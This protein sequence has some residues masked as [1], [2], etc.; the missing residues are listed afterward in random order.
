MQ[1]PVNGLTEIDLKR[2][3]VPTLEIDV[4]LLGRQEIRLRL[5]GSGDWF[6]GPEGVELELVHWNWLMRPGSGD[7]LNG[8]NVLL[9]EVISHNRTRFSLPEELL[10]PGKGITAKL[11]SRSCPFLL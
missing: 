11:F 8:E 2:L 6:L 5:I 10:G 9:R 1:F 7:R 4:D 3:G